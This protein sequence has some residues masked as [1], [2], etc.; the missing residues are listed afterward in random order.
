MQTSGIRL[1]PFI[2][3]PTFVGLLGL[4]ILFIGAYRL[5]QIAEWISNDSHKH[6]LPYVI[7]AILAISYPLGLLVNRFLQ[8]LFIPREGTI[9][10]TEYMEILNKNSNGLIVKE[11]EVKYGFLLFWRLS[12]VAMLGLGVGFSRIW[13]DGNVDGAFGLLVS[14]ILFTVLFYVHKKEGQDN[15]KLGEEVMKV[16]DITPQDSKETE[17]S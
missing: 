13:Y 16:L 5:R 11:L 7:A 10:R 6:L 14:L 2:A 3:L 17:D 4:T 9:Q 8:W 12:A 15:R 1:F